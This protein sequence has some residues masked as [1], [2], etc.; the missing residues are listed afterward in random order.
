M[1]KFILILVFYGLHCFVLAQNEFTPLKYWITFTDKDN[2]NFNINKPGEFLSTRSIERR[3]NQN[4]DID[5]TDL[6][7]NQ[8]YIDSLLLDTNIDL[9][10]A[11]RWF[12]AVVAKV[13]E[14]SSVDRLNDLDFVKDILYV[15]PDLPDNYKSKTKSL[16]RNKA[17][18]T[19]NYSL[20]SNNKFLSNISS[21]SYALSA[22]KPDYGYAKE[23]ISIINGIP[24]H[25]RG[26]DGAGKMIALMDAGYTNVDSI[27]AFTHLWDNEQIIGWKD[28]VN[29]DHDIFKIHTHGTY[30]LSVMAT[31]M[32]SQMIGAATGADYL[33]LRT[34]DAASEFLI[35]ECNWI[36]AAEYAD[37]MGVDIVNTSL[38]YTV[39]DDPD[40]NHT[41][42]D[43]DGKTTLISKAANFA[44]EKGMLVVNSAGNYGRQD[45][46]YISAPADSYGGIAV[47]AVDVE[48]ERALFSSVGP[49]F[50]NRVKP[51]VMAVGSNA[52]AVNENGK[53]IKAHGTSFSSPLIAAM[54]ACLWQSHPE[55]SVKDIKKAII[56]SSDRIYKP[57]SLYGFGIPDFEKA[58]NLLKKDFDH[59]PIFKVFPNPFRDNFILNIFLEKDTKMNLQLIN[60]R[61]QLIFDNTYNAFEGFNTF[62]PFQN[63]YKLDQGLYILRI[64]TGI[65]VFSTRIL[66]TAE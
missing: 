63:M 5:S 61:G 46:K 43:M 22:D 47:G 64:D 16:L 24:L 51:D 56:E 29:P 37:S 18:N 28:F 60:I 25:E 2:S 59:D 38:G 45:W 14:P 36:A 44:F 52:V 57:D 49:S 26:Y 11:S 9:I 7:V 15:K 19:S 8:I 17:Y 55:R 48:G 12:N 13:P 23:Q 40:Q 34:E 32:P 20:N 41:Y 50:D 30:V 31:F 62:E 54:A 66:K 58:Y 27:E 3:I 42:A 6:P 35:E 53:L 65:D 33:L 10:Y 1:A 39:F 21:C 4:I